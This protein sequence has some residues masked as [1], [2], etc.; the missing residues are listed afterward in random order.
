[1]GRVC[2]VV[3]FFAVG[4]ALLGT[5]AWSSAAVRPRRRGSCCR[6]EPGGAAPRQRCLR[7]LVRGASKYCS[8]HAPTS[9]LLRYFHWYIAGACPTAALPKRTGP[10][11]LYFQCQC[12]PWPAAAATRAAAAGRS[13]ESEYILA[14]E[15]PTAAA[16]PALP[17][18]LPHASRQ[19]RR[20]CPRG[21]RRRR[22]KEKGQW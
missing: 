1:M 3:R 2:A 18:R 7:H 11:L 15:A 16:W 4:S 12:T 13:T 8:L 10:R 5:R 21:R 6:G 9:A 19:R 22:P 20:C 14:P 17:S